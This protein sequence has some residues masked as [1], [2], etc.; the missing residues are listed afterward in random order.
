MLSALRKLVA[1][2]PKS[3]APDECIFSLDPQKRKLLLLDLKIVLRLP[4]ARLALP[5]VANLE[6]TIRRNHERIRI[7]YRAMLVLVR[8][9][10]GVR[11][12]IP[13]TSP[14]REIM[15]AIPG[16]TNSVLRDPPASSSAADE[17][18]LAIR[19]PGL[20]SAE[21]EAEVERIRR[22]IAQKPVPRQE[23][24]A[25]PQPEPD[26]P[27]AR[28]SA[29]RAGLPNSRA[30]GA[31]EQRRFLEE[32]AELME[33]VALSTGE[34]P[35]EDFAGYVDLCILNGDHARVI[36][37]LVERVTEQP[38]AWAW[39]RLLELLEAVRDPRFG[40]LRASFHA[41]VADACPDLLPD[42]GE[43]AI[44]VY[45]VR[46]DALR[47]RECEEIGPNAMR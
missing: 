15:T 45:G 41:W 18:D 16:L 10:L 12:R 23:N 9:L 42:D 38:R 7:P 31:L 21:Q 19:M 6:T 47:E 24:A 44:T 14:L 27:V 34:L 28:S 4:G 46:R 2:R 30:M 25:R 39:I 43:A 13:A 3:P 8:E 20:P 29:P 35:D 17:H 37:M 40:A 36:E 32:S 22:L 33:S 26:F 1:G 5:N 11:H